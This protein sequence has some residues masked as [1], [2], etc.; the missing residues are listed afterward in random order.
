M[1]SSTYTLCGGVSNKCHAT[2]PDSCCAQ[3]VHH[4]SLCSRYHSEAVLRAG[5]DHSLVN[6]FAIVTSRVRHRAHRM[7]MELPAVA[8]DEICLALLH[9]LNNPPEV[10]QVDIFARECICRACIY[11]GVTATTNLNICLDYPKTPCNANRTRAY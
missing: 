5:G 8:L 3:S 9:F 11:L 2:F 6:H 7:P 4:T 10:C 1:N